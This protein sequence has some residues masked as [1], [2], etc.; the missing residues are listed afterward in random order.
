MLKRLVEAAG[1]DYVQ[2]RAL[3][4][5]RM[6]ID[7]SALLGAYGPIAARRAA[8]HL[9][10]QWLTFGMLGSLATFVIIFARDMFFAATV[11]V[12]VI[13]SL[14][15]VFVLLQASTLISPDDYAVIGYR[16]VSSTTYFAARVSGLLVMTAEIVVLAGYPSV[17][18]F[19]IRSGGSLGVTLAAFTAIVASSTSATLL[20]AAMY[21]SLLQRLSPVKLQRAIAMCTL[22]VLFVGTAGL[23]IYAYGQVGHALIDAAMLCSVSYVTLQLDAL[24]DPRLPVS[25]PVLSPRG[26]V[27]QRGS[28]LV[29]A[30][31][32][33]VYEVVD[34]GR[35]LLFYRTRWTLTASVLAMAALV[36]WLNRL[37]R[38]RVMKRIQSAEYFE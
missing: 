20:V 8:V 3:L 24:F 21:G 17:V 30:L 2:W 18:A 7:Y 34:Y 19:L 38:A 10:L 37:T 6:M 9:I 27:M 1:V 5:T 31:C 25:T 29:F 11:M 36:W 15:A 32:L 16:P 23:F 4:R 22:P 13:A 14:V 33:L 35:P 26:P 28:W 12:T